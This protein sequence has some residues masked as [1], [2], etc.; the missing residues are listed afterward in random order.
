MNNKVVK[1]HDGAKNIMS[2]SL[3]TVQCLYLIET[4]MVNLFVVVEN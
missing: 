2:E 4:W 1:P 3:G